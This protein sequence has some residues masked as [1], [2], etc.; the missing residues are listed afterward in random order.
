MSAVWAQDSITPTGKTRKRKTWF[1]L[2]KIITE[3]ECE[4]VEWDT[5][6]PYMSDR[7]RIVWRKK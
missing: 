5:N 1:G 7:T 3:E 4:L 2:G 6:C